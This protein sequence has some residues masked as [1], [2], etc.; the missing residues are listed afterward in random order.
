MQERFS[1]TDI[2]EALRR[3]YAALPPLSDDFDEKMLA[4]LNRKKRQR[5]MRRLI[6]WPSMAAAATVALLLTLLP[7]S[8]SQDRPQ[9][10]K[11]QNPRMIT[12]DLEKVDSPSDKEPQDIGEARR[13]KGKTSGFRQSQRKRKS[14]DETLQAEEAASN[15][16]SASSTSD[17]AERSLAEENS[18]PLSRHRDDMRSRI[19]KEFD[20]PSL[21]MNSQN[22]EYENT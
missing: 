13:G 2:R 7:A 22:H 11:V 21:T 8:E 3:H 17:I 14:A 19:R 6:I 16:A 1:D 12:D 9:L 5:K 18:L 4:A 15:S 20:T 10:A